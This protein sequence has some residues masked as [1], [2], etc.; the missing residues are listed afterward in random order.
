MNIHL[1]IEGEE[2][3]KSVYSKWIPLVNP[4]LTVVDSLN[5]VT[6]DRVWILAAYGYPY[7]LEMI[8]S[9]VDDVF[10]NDC[11]DRLVVAIDSEE[12]NYE[13]KYKEIKAH[14]ESF[15]K[16]IDYRIIV[17][18]FCLEAWALGNEAIVKRNSKDI[19]VRKFRSLHDVL[20]KD[21]AL[22]PGLQEKKLNR[23]QFSEIYLRKLLNDKYR[24]LTYTKSNAG[25]LLNDKYFQRVKRRHN[26][27]CHIASFQD[28][29]TSFV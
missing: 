24:N 5:K 10:E 17:Q 26:K 19:E 20:I 29:L 8:K 21:P 12:M 7:Y 1:L 6:E 22:L 4:R 11:L 13:E 25:A 14:I 23:A 16:S 28:F 3:A 27:T 9:A 2:A 18:H 15:Q